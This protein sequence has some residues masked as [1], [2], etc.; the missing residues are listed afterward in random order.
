M[1]WLSENDFL[2]GWTKEDLQELFKRMKEAIPRNDSLKYNSRVAKLDWE[3]IKFGKYTA[4]EC[5]TRWKTIEKK[6][7]GYRILSE[8]LTD[9]SDWLEKPW[10]DFYQSGK[11]VC[12]LYLLIIDYKN[13]NPVPS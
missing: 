8:L 2:N 10:T 4:E 3:K 5:Q 9:A 12:F 11:K 13:L 7:R 6:L 1:N